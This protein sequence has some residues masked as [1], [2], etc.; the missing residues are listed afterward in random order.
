MA[1]RR[2]EDASMLRPLAGA[3]VIVVSSLTVA[4]SAL[5]SAQA[6][7]NSSSPKTANAVTTSASPPGGIKRFNEGATHSPQLEQQ[8][9]R[10]ATVAPK[11][12][13]AVAAVANAAV[14]NSAMASAAVAPTVQG[15]DVASFQHPNGAAINWSSVAAAGYKF[16]FIKATEG[17]YYT[18]PYYAKDKSGAEAA[19]LFVAPYVFAIP[20]YSGGAF[21]A[22]YAIAQAA[23]QPDGRTLPIIL[24]IEYD[25][26]VSSDGTNQCYGLTPAQM[27]SWIAAFST[28]A[29]RR[30]GQQTVIYSTAKWWQTCTGNST[31]F[32]ADPLW[33]ASPTST[34]ALPTSWSDYTYWQYTNSAPL[35]GSTT[36]TTDASYINSNALELAALPAQSNASASA[37]KSVTAGALSGGA[38]AT[39]SASGLPAGLSIDPAS[40]T[41]SGTLSGGPTAFQSSVTAAVS[42]GP[43]A[44]QSFTWNVHGAVSMAS[45]SN[46]TST[47]GNP[48]RIPLSA[49]DSL[50]GCTLTFSASGLPSG[51]TMSSCGVIS[52]WP[53]V[54]GQSNVT[55]HV[56]DGAGAAL[57]QQSFTWTVNQS[58]GTGPAGQITLKRDGKCLAALSGTNIAI[59]RCST[60]KNQKWRIVPDGTVRINGQCLTAKSATGTASAALDLAGCKGGQ[61][62]QLNSN[63]VLMNLTDGRC[64]ADTGVPNGSPAVAAACQ[65]TKNNTGSASTPSTSQQWTLP[66]GPLTSGIAG[67]CASTWHPARVPLGPVTT[68]LCDGTAAQAWTISPDGTIRARGRCL[69]LNGGVMTPGTQV[70]LV[71]CPA[72]GATPS[73]SLVWQLTGGP[74]GVQLLNPAAGLC[75][76]EPGDRVAAGV[77]LVLGGCVAGDPGMSWRVS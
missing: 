67:Y 14:A 23:Y 40:G 25:P 66:A 12:Q 18:N 64:L 34:P 54:S 9:A 29:H 24:D 6:S 7:P 53:Q 41:M 16:A 45:V 28:E 74:T 47:L 39:Y 42:G 38:V 68:R 55:V 56:T 33:I 5:I 73:A 11:V 62:W 22:D 72:S 4:G 8:F 43:S 69:G 52:G 21:Q 71:T 58:S 10:K 1:G 31:A 65:A 61:R 32:S 51:L 17:S 19:G 57:A 36:V 30:T 50:P 37:P 3:A 59:E 44:T 27:V 77:R 26:Y 13:A 60:N 15:I 46:R 48:A 76:S 20:N 2:R 49:P 70:R 63:A 35:P 75:V